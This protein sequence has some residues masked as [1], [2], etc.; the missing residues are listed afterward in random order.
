MNFGTLP[1]KRLL[2]ITSSL[3]LVGSA[4]AADMAA[5]PYTKAPVAAAIPFSWTSCYVGGHVGGGWSKTNFTDPG[6]ASGSPGFP[7]TTTGA[8][9]GDQIRVDGNAG[10]IGGVQAGCDYQ[11]SNHWVVGLAGDFSG[12]DLHGTAN[13]PFFG[14]KNGN[15]ATL[16]S[17][18]DW[19]ASV[20]GRVGYTWDRFMIYGKGGAG[21]AR[22]TYS[23]NN[24]VNTAGFD[25]RAAFVFTPCN[26]STSTDR[27]G[28]VAGAGAEW[29]FTPNWSVLVEYDHYGFDS[30]R[31]G[32]LNPAGPSTALIDIQ[33]DIDIVKVGVN[34]R[35]GGLPVV[36]KY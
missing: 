3:V 22:D 20:T 34:Y 27:V 18:T 8:I 13:D 28:W 29:A 2:L 33:Q 1:M 15:P 9:P 35:F 24:F 32:F 23:L 10:V 21:F 30:K 7:I 14:G 12:G 11:F 17:R 16:S 26:A 4:Q 36:A 19:L 25:C 31:V 6:I 5:R